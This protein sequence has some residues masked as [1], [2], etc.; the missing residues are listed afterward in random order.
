MAALVPAAPARQRLEALARVGVGLR[1]AAQLAQV[2]VRTAQGIRTGRRALVCRQVALA[3]LDL[4]PS[5]ARGQRV[6][7]Y[8]TRRMIAI[9]QTEGFTRA[10]LARRLGLR[11]PTLQLNRRRVTVRNAL[12]VRAFYAFV[13]A[14][15]GADEEAGAASAIS[16]CTA[17]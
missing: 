13:T 16:V 5:L 15:G 17:K 6:N 11:S 1:R 12:K 2:S 4:R 14:H 3:I 9:L 8:E 7:G 10:A